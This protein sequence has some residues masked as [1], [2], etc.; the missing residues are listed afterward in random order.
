MSIGNTGVMVPATMAWTAIGMNG[1]DVNSGV[2][3]SAGDGVITKEVALISVAWTVGVSMIVVAT[4]WDGGV[5]AG[6]TVAV[7]GA[8]GV[9]R[10]AGAVAGRFRT[11]RTAAT[12]TERTPAT[13][14]QRARTTYLRRAR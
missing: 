13:R 9:A 12:A 10:G 3:V 14:S 1:V 7:P 2:E 4:G 8:V 5:A 6:A 11:R